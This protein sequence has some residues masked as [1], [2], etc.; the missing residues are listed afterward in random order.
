MRPDASELVT[1]YVHELMQRVRREV[2][3]TFVE[4]RVQALGGQAVRGV[5]ERLHAE[6]QVLLQGEPATGKTTT[7]KV[8]AYQLAQAY[9][10]SLSA[11][12]PILIFASTLPPPGDD[13]WNWL[14]TAAAHL[15]EGSQDAVDVLA[16]TLKDG[17]AH[18]FVDG[19]DEIRDAGRRFRVAEALAALQSESPELKLCVSTRASDSESA[20]L[21]DRFAVWSLL[22]FDDSQARQLLAVLT[23][24]LGP[25]IEHQLANAPELGSLTGSPLMLRLLAFY[26][27]G[28]GFK[29]PRSRI[30]LFE[31]LTD[32]L[33]ARERQKVPKPVPTEVVHRVHEL[34]AEAMAREGTESLPISKLNGALA[35]DIHS[36]HTTWDQDW[37]LRYIM[38][39]VVLL[40]QNSSS[41]VA[42]E[43]R[44]GV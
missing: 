14:A 6:T 44:G 17:C 21:R 5:L 43:H 29:L 30:Q 34:I 8:V 15:T 19:L 23:A 42:F 13:L 27:D 24:S 9:V 2:L 41:T 25:D 26:S 10:D 22:P 18:L 37:V 3:E 12:C 7:I 36:I 11:V 31:D 32:A 16:A 39:R 4:P 35:D 40:V 1:T 20:I 28:R 33:L 38:D